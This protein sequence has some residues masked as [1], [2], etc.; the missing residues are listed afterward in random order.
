[1]RQLYFKRAK[2]F[3]AVVD[4]VEK[5]AQGSISANGPEPMPDWVTETLT[6]KL[7]IKDKSIIDL[8]PPSHKK[9][10]AAEVTD[11]KYTESASVGKDAVA[12]LAEA[13]EPEPVDDDEEVK[14]TAKSA[15]V[16]AGLKSRGR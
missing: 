5:R 2:M 7:S 4:G 10:V 8:T 3:L 15:R 13:D 16:P 6:Y 9:G 1:M 14:P 12:A 11:V